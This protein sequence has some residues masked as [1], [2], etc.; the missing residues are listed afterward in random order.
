MLADDPHLTARPGG[1]L[2][3][4]QPLRVVLDG[5]GRVPA[6][7]R[8]FDAAAQTLLLTTAATPEAWRTAITARGVEVAIL[9][10]RTDGR[11]VD[12]G[13]ALRLLGE[14]EVLTL[15]VEGGGELLGA[16]FDQR[17]VDR[18]YAVIAPVVIGAASAPTAV[19]GR[20]AAVMHEAPRLREVTVER[21]GEDILIDGIPTWPGPDER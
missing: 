13:A 18:L 6:A 17:C 7:A 14:R 16:L 4:R 20:G 11:H 3:A 9:P 15:L 1:V 19:A 12:L 2:A 21:L 5:G 10:A 8:V